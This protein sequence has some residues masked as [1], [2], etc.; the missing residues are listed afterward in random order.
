MSKGQ[1][2]GGNN[3]GIKLTEYD[4]QWTAYSVLAPGGIDGNW[5]WY[6]LAGGSPPANATGSKA[7]GHVHIDGYGGSGSYCTMTG[8]VELST[9][10]DTIQFTYRVQSVHDG[11]SSGTAILRLQDSDESN[12]QILVTSTSG[13][14]SG[15]ITGLITLTIDGN[16]LNIRHSYSAV[17]QSGATNTANTTDNTNVDITAWDGIYIQGRVNLNSSVDIGPILHYPTLIGSNGT[18]GE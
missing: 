15:L 1:V 5:T 4:D 2:I 7:L 8:D 18:N 16:S 11:A 6:L 17:A 14:S 9:L 12:T 3:S 10:G 13:A